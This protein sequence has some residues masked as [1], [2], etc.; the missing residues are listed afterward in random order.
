V[1]PE[2]VDNAGPDGDPVQHRGMAPFPMPTT[3]AD[4]EPRP[5]QL[6]D[7]ARFLTQ[8]STVLSMTPGTIVSLVHL[9]T[10]KQ[11]LCAAVRIDWADVKPTD[12]MDADLSRTARS[13][14][15]HDVAH[16]LWGSLPTARGRPEHAFVTVVARPGRVVFGPPEYRVLSG[17]RYA[18]HLLPAFQG[19]LLL[20]TPHGWRAFI[21][22][23]CG[24]V[25]ALDDEAS[26]E[27]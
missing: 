5:S 27:A 3:T 24:T 16:D 12:Q 14:L 1:A 26:W 25:P 7:P 23:S 22:D 10:T 9:P 11:A 21:D 2:S 13:E 8:L 4:P 19:D 6:R 18:N 20:V 15:L 17:W